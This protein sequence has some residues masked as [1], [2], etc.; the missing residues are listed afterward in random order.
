MWCFYKKYHRMERDLN[1]CR[2]V[3]PRLWSPS[4]YPRSDA[5]S[6]DH[7]DHLWSFHS[8]NAG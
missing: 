7:T 3:H 2:L 4:D 5:G 1:F 8:D 6:L